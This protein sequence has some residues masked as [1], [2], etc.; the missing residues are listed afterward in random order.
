MGQTVPSQAGIFSFAP[1][2]V[3]IGTEFTF[4]ENA[5]NWYK[6]RSPRVDLGT[7]QD[8]QI[9]PLEVGGIIVA[10][11]A[12]K[13]AHFFGG[14]I[15]MLPRLE[16]NF[17]Y[18]LE[19]L[20]G[21][22]DT[23]ADE[24]ADGGSVT[25]LN[26]HF[27]TFASD[28]FSIP[29]LSARS[30]RPG[31]EAADYIGETGFDCKVA[32]MRFTVPQMGKMQ[33]R[34][35]L[36]GR[37]SYLDEAP[38]WTYTNAD[39]EEAGSVPEAG[40][41]SFSIA[42]TEFPA[43]GCV[44]DVVNN[45]TTPQQEMILGS[46]NPDHF[47]PL[48]RGCTIRFTYKWSNP[49]FYQQILTGTASGETWDSLPF[50]T[51]SNGSLAFEA[52]FESPQEISDT[53]PL[54]RSYRIL[55]RADRVTWSVDGPPTMQGGGIMTQN[56]TGTVLA[57]DDDQEYFIIVVENEQDS[58]AWPASFPPFL[59]ILPATNATVDASDN[60]YVLAVTTSTATDVDANYNT[61]TLVIQTTS[62]P[63]AGDTFQIKNI[64]TGAGEV[65][66][67]GTAVSYEGVTVAT[68]SVSG[69]TQTNATALTLTFNAAATMAAIQA[70]IR[71]YQFKT[72][73]VGSPR[74]VTFTLTDAASLSDS[75]TLVITVQA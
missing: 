56:Y 50:M 66:V 63:N 64:G 1:Q 19:A 36:V 67:S 8:Q 23:Q 7:I 69:A 3:K 26:S 17:G 32:M 68:A 48:T 60:T 47:V 13:Q 38:S 25:G 6:V 57:A 15:D 72:S 14:D 39:F 10:T 31:V 61:G 24:D 33:V 41:G 74:T 75:D 22:V 71:A 51:E 53:P 55:F 4:D 20:L 43:M 44:I 12:Y 59:E 49:D 40:R 11:G 45:L 16:G 28:S 70:I 21:A 58:Y 29:W 54:D 35:G 9:F 5:V 62:N 18:L 37:D 34:M 46:F 27:F 42:G 30:L 73:A 2:P 52:I 65:G